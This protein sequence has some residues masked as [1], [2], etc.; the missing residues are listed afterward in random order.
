MEYNL[1]KYGQIESLGSITL[2]NAQ[3]VSILNSTSS[4]ISM[5]GSG[6]VSGTIDLECDLG[7]RIYIDKVYYYFDSDTASGTIASTVQFGFKNEDFETF[8]DLNTFIGPNYYYTIVSGT[9]APRYI[10]LTHIIETG[11]SGILNGFEVTNNE[12]YVDFGIDGSTTSHGVSLAIE[13]AT[14]EIDE[15]Y[16]YN[17]GPSRATA[18]VVLEPQNTKVDEALFLSENQDGPWLGIYQDDDLIT[19]A[20]IYDSGTS[21]NLTAYPEYLKLSSGQTE[22][23]YLT[24]IVEASSSQKLTRVVLK[25][26][27][28]SP[29][30]LIA[31]DSDD[32]YETIE[33]R[34]SNTPPADRNRYTEVYE[35]GDVF[36]IRYRW[37]EDSSVDETLTL[38]F[39]APNSSG[40]RREC[41]YDVWVDSLTEDVYMIIKHEYYWSYDYR[42]SVYFVVRRKTGTEYSSAIMSGG[43]VDGCA[44]NPIFNCYRLQYNS[45]GGFWTYYYYRR[46]D[47]DTPQYRLRYY[48]STLGVTYSRS[49]TPDQGSFLYDMSAAYGNTDLW[50][51]DQSLATVFK[52]DNSGAILRSYLATSDLRGIAATDDGGCWFIQGE[53]L[54]RL[55]NSGVLI[56]TVELPS[57]SVS[58]VYLDPEG[59][60]WLQDGWDII[61]LNED[62]SEDFR[63]TR[64]YLLFMEVVR[65]GVIT[66]EHS[67]GSTINPTASFISKKYKKTIRTW[68]YPTE[69]DRCG[70]WDYNRYGFSF[71]GFDDLSGDVTSHFPV[72]TDTTWQN[73]DW[74]KVSGRDYNLSNDDYHQFRIT[75]RADDSSNSPEFYGLWHQTAVEVP[76]INVNDYGKFYLKA[77]VSELSEADI[78]SYDSKIRAWWYI[79]DVE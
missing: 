75:L 76:N 12:S 50:Y 34:H 5:P 60:F 35:S 4:N 11:V 2:S 23:T 61:R 22:G 56:D 51:T 25:S 63:V 58:Y 29:N 15:L 9:E 18:Y 66:K 33:V 8:T 65:S 78:A 1:A 47:S 13:N 49:A 39:A 55:N 37:M 32:T 71:Q 24:R 44:S 70:T 7:A 74:E 17:S 14:S 16:V 52:I 38:S 54:L 31:V 62:G 42:V 53:E 27:Y 40:A 43:S 72:A 20:G 6:T 46:L 3:L 41:H 19:G 67:G 69:G 59:G 36:Y 45:T 28:S 10:K 64:D 21:T 79:E 26:Y 68:N 57:D 48:N 77:D 73:L 30:G